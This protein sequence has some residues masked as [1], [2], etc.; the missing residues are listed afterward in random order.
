MYPE[1][2]YPSRLLYSIYTSREAQAIH[3]N[4]FQR[5]DLSSNLVQHQHTNHVEIDLH[6]VRE[7]VA[8]GQVHVL[9]V[10]MTS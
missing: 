2:P 7:K 1:V 9:H 10:P 5:H 3:H 8:I 6:F 4:N